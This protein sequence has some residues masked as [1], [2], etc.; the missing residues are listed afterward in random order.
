MRA[1]VRV[2]VASLRVDSPVKYN[3]GWRLSCFLLCI[4]RAYTLSAPR[5]CPSSTRCG[6]SPAVQRL[7]WYC[8]GVVHVT[9]SAQVD[10]LYMCLTAVHV[11]CSVHAAVAAAASPATALTVP[12]TATA[13]CSLTIAFQHALLHA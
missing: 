6:V 12:A 2:R 13:R 11:P 1:R 4:G 5:R 3:A 8:R 7:H 9:C 10:R